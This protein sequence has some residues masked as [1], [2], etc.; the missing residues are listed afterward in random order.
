LESS[1]VKTSALT[2]ETCECRSGW[3]VLRDPEW[4]VFVGAVGNTS[5]AHVERQVS[6]RINVSDAKGSIY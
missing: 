2:D 5:T 3:F 4:R 1:A 6:G